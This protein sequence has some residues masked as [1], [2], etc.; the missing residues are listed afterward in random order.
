MWEV[1]REIF[2]FKNLLFG[3]NS[4][5]NGIIFVWAN[6]FKLSNSVDN[7]NIYDSAYICLSYSFCA[8]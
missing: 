5:Y 3:P 7:G 2:V 1:G 4:I 6:K 8:L